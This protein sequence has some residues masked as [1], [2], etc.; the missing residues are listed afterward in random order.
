M[1]PMALRRGGRGKL[2]QPGRE[3]V[4]PYHSLIPDDGHPLLSAI[5][6]FGDQGEVVLSDRLLGGVESAVGT[7]SDLE[8]STGRE[9]GD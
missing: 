4:A 8:I 7:A 1:R 2:G 9:T 3:T 6:A 5:G